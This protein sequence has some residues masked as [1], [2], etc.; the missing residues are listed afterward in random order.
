[1]NIILALN[2]LILAGIFAILVLF[3]LKIYRFYRYLS[4]IVRTF[5]TSPGKD[6]PSP[7]AFVA[8]TLATTIGH[9]VAVEAKTTLMGKS[10]VIARQEQGVMGDLASDGLASA[11]PVMS[12][13]LSS[14]PSLQKRL[15]KN[16]GLLSLVIGKLGQPGG[17]HP[18]ESKPVDLNKFE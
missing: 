2:L 4:D 10:S 7:L 14:F 18:A 6:Q 3:Y 9:A 8:Q 13:L 16:P 15:L 11:S 17:N 1:M 12:A 5:L